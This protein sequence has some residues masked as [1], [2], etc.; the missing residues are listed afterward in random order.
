M[1]QNF[2]RKKIGQ[3]WAFLEA[4]PLKT[5]K[6]KNLRIEPARPAFSPSS[7]FKNPT[8][9]EPAFSWLV[10]IPTFPLNPPSLDYRRA[11]YNSLPNTKKT[12]VGQ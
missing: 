4:T 12:R 3:L 10:Y 2:F 6:K 9:P 1:M 5:A 7:H 8:Q 11:R